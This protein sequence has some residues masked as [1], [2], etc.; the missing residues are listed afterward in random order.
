MATLASMI[1][2]MAAEHKNPMVKDL[3]QGV[4]AAGRLRLENSVLSQMNELQLDER[5]ALQALG[6]GH[7]RL[8][9]DLCWL[10]FE[11]GGQQAGYLVSY[12]D[13]ALSFRL[14][15]VEGGYVYHPLGEVRMDSAGMRLEV[16]YPMSPKEQES[17]LPMFGEAGGDILRFALLISAKGSPAII[18]PGEDFVR[19]NKRRAKAGRPPVLG[20]RPVRWSLS[21]EARSTRP[22]GAD[23]GRVAAPHMVRGHLKTR[24]NGI[25]WWRS[26][27]RSLVPG[28]ALPAGR[29]YRVTS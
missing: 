25:Y 2:A 7:L 8:P 6:R 4:A 23:G 26:H 3:A 12:E 14:A 19:L 21:G 13:R 24:K 27:Y 5:A 11:D 9:Y 10:E 20:C 29:D 18:G 22:P 16:D 15:F 17:S 28:D 1:I